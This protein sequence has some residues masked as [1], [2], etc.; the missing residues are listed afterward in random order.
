[1]IFSILELPLFLMRHIISQLF[2]KQIILVD[3]ETFYLVDPDVLKIGKSLTKG[4]LPFDIPQ[5]SIW[6]LV[7]FPPYKIQ[8]G[9]FL[10][11]FFWLVLNIRMV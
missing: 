2:S 3:L 4:A 10:N 8:F 1:M 11:P 6:E 5:G 7:L 9:Q